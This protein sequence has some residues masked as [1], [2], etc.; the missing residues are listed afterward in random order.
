MYIDFDT[1]KL[2]RHV[3]M[4]SSKTLVRLRAICKSV[5]SNVLAFEMVKLMFQRLFSA[6]P[7]KKVK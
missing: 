4:A 2:I 3:A 5:E 1:P 6:R 7:V